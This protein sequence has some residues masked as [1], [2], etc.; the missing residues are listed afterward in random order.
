MKIH[1]LS[2]AAA[3]LI[4]AGGAIH[5][6]Y[7]PSPGLTAHAEEES[8]TDFYPDNSYVLFHLYSDHAVLA[9]YDG[10]ETSYTVPDTVEGLPV[11]EIGDTAFAGVFELTS[12]VIPDTVTRIGDDAFNF[13]FYL[14]EITL[15]SSL[16]YIGYRAFSL[17]GVKTLS[18]PASL[19]TIA[20]LTSEKETF[21]QSCPALTSITVDSKNP[22]FSAKDGVLFDKK[23]TVLYRYPPAKEGSSY[24]MPS[25][26]KSIS[27]GAFH[28]SA[29]ESITVSAKLETV[30]V[31]AFGYCE[32][33]S[34]IE[35]PGSVKSIGGSAFIKCTALEELTL[36]EGLE[37]IG[38]GS[39]SG[40]S[41][42]KEVTIPSTV[43]QISDSAFVTCQ[44]LRTVTI[45]SKDCVLGSGSE[46]FSDSSIN[47]YMG[48]TAQD[49]AETFQ[50]RFSLIHDLGDLDGDTRIDSSDASA[51]LVEYAAIQTGAEP[52]VDKSIG[53][54]NGDGYIDSS[55]ASDILQY[56][57]FTQ[58]GGAATLTEFLEA[59]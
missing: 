40:C 52:S 44:S 47:G 43:S 19:K 11:T 22:Y 21:C 50:Q 55:D 3:A 30:G 49:Y 4:F 33:L 2:A 59:R 7:L 42:I 27:D 28:K 37:T 15:P 38:R 10:S 56:Y 57:S 35:L 53:D 1:I 16:E 36:N 24:T 54:V 51:V 48:S 9:K 5:G 32:S 26:V 29:L 39:F 58:T 25:T 31:R 46:V 45:R 34:A 8:Y 12:L 23:K 18:L 14:E 13:A 6:P 20:D 41:A 17:C